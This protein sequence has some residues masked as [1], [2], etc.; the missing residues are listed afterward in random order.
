MN[1][2]SQTPS[3]ILPTHRDSSLCPFTA[4]LGAQLKW[5]ELYLLG[6]P[7]LHSPVP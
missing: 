2:L 3:L 4:L 6:R 7:G 5:Q 1:L